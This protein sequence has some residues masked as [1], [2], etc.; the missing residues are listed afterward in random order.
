MGRS[1]TCPG[2]GNRST[3]RRVRDAPETS[4][5]AVSRT[6]PA[7][8][9]VRA[10]DVRARVVDGARTAPP[11]PLPSALVSRQPDRSAGYAAGPVA[12]V[13]EV[14]W[15]AVRGC[16]R[17]VPRTTPRHCRWEH[18][19]GDERVRPEHRV[20][21]AADAAVQQPRRGE[22][23]G[24][25]QPQVGAGVAQFQDVEDGAAVD[26]QVTGDVGAGVAQ[27]PPGGSAR[28]HRNAMGLPPLMPRENDVDV[29]PSD[30][31]RSRSGT[32]RVVRR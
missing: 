25:P 30:A 24:R 12:R 29:T 9:R 5:E 21:R 2:S 6:G 26:V 32:R 11:A 3:S 4:V 31:G 10:V 15:A 18:V 22:Q 27:L 7:P 14:D 8:G 20:G 23:I 1:M 17:P 28:S 13:R 16:D 19:T